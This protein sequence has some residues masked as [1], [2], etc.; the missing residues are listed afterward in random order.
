M[1]V[2]ARGFPG[3]LLRLDPAFAYVEPPS[4]WP[5]PWAECLRPAPNKILFRHMSCYWRLSLVI[6][7]GPCLK[8]PSFCRRS[9]PDRSFGQTQTTGS[10][11]PGCSRDRR[12]LRFPSRPTES[13]SPSPRSQESQG[14]KRI[15]TTLFPWTQMG[16][17]PFLDAGSCGTPSKTVVGHFPKFKGTHPQKAQ[18][19]LISIA[20][21]SQPPSLS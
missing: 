1:G 7:E 9:P 18:M 3:G 19:M 5:L 16:H 21:T 8:S 6:V 13:E 2:D 10:V 15:W 17:A 20:I 4:S 11:P 14:C 12:T